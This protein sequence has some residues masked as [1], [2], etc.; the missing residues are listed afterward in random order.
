ML[1]RFRSFQRGTVGL[2]R[3]TGCKVA[4]C[5][6]WRMILSSRNRTRAARVW[7]EVGRL[8]EFFSNLQL[9][10]LVTLMQIDLQ[11]PT[12][13]LWKDLNLLFLASCIPFKFIGMKES[14]TALINITLKKHF[15]H[16][17]S[18]ILKN[19]LQAQKEHQPNFKNAWKISFNVWVP[20]KYHDSL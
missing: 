12:A 2:C 8:A 9:W 20:T 10:Q 14:A 17:S 13:P 7:F 19:C 11:R 16:L 15:L 6:S 5:Q 1:R 18:Y 4:S 3:S